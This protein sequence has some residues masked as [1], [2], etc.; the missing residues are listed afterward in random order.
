MSPSLVK[1]LQVL[2][3]VVVGSVV[4]SLLSACS[5]AS[6]P[7]SSSPFSV[8]RPLFSESKYGKSSPRVTTH[9]GPLKKG[10]GYRRLG[11]PYKIAGQWYVPR[12]DPNYDQVGVA[13][14]Y[15]YDFHGRKTA[16]G[17]LF[18]MH[19]L[20][21]AHPTLPLPS[22]AYVT[23]LDNNR[24]V[25]VRINDRGPY[26]GGRII[27]LSQASAK[28]LGYLR[29]GRARVRVKYAGPAPMNGD[30]THE[31]HFLASAQ[32]RTSVA[33]RVPRRRTYRRQQASANT[34]GRWSPTSY[35]AS[36]RTTRQ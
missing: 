36:L 35:R 8:S 20:T 22:Y 27:D 31:R 13:S 34:A 33:A 1:Y 2:K 19:A 30:D 24:T 9:R 7:S 26:V 12:H 5:Q 10:G 6:G 28:A 11:K 3:R 25:L 15:G 17:E 14:W 32:N 16:N 29:Q 18:D 4:A 21:A 23:N